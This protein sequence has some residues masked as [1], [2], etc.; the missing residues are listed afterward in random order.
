MVIGIVYYTQQLFCKFFV[1]IF[2]YTDDLDG[3]FESEAERDAEAFGQKLFFD[4]TGV[5]LVSESPN[6]AS[7]N[8]KIKNMTLKK[9]KH[10]KL[11]KVYIG[12][13]KGLLGFL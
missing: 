13:I 8:K 9:M 6:Y 10:L 4:V 5:N 3:Y 7:G 12:K 1:I 2:D 11:N